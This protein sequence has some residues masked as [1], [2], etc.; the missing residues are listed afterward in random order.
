MVNWDDIT[1]NHLTM[2][3]S[4]WLCYG[5]NADRRR[6]EN[7]EMERRPGIRPGGDERGEREP[8]GTWPEWLPMET[9]SRHWVRGRGRAILTPRPFI[10]VHHR[11]VP[12]RPLR[13][14]T[15]GFGWVVRGPGLDHLRP[16][17][18]GV[19]RASCGLGINLNRP[20]LANPLH[21]QPLPPAPIQEEGALDASSESSDAGKGSP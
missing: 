4:R 12:P 1:N 6:Q 11:V 19:G 18:P 13:G 7:E 10:Q 9:F 8:Q 2:G 14:V 3:R 15:V 5:M 20:C 16:H 17:I 21:Y